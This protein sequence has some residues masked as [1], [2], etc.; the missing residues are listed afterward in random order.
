MKSNPVFDII[1]GI[2]ISHSEYLHSVPFDT[3]LFIVSASDPTH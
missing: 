2:S 3:G 1:H